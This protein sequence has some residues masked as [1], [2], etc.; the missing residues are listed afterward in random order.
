MADALKGAMA[1][2]ELK[3]GLKEGADV[4]KEGLSSV[5]GGLSEAKLG[6]TAKEALSSAA[7]GLAG[8]G[9]TVSQ[10]ISG[11][12]SAVKDAVRTGTPTEGGSSSPKKSFPTAQD[13][14][15]QPSM[16]SIVA[17]RVDGDIEDPAYI[18]RCETPRGEVWPILRRFST[19]E[20]LREDLLKDENPALKSLDFPAS[21][22]F[23]GTFG[24]KLFEGSG[25]ERGQD[26]ATPAVR[27]RKQQLESW[28]NEVSELCPAE[29]LLLAFFIDDNSVTTAEALK[30]G[31]KV[32]SS[33]P[34]RAAT[35]ESSPEAP[36]SAEEQARKQRQNR[37]AL[38]ALD[39]QPVRIKLT[40]ARPPVAHREG[41]GGAQDTEKTRQRRKEDE[42]A[43]LA[44]MR[45]DEPGSEASPR[46]AAEPASAAEPEPDSEPEPE[47]APTSRW[48]SLGGA[49]GALTSFK[50]E[51]QQE[52]EAVADTV[53][54][55][56]STVGDSVTEG[57]SAIRQEVEDASAAV[58][59]EIGPG[60]KAYLIQCRCAEDDV[61]PTR[62][63]SPCW[64]VRRSLH[65]V[66]EL[67]N[68]LL[69]DGSP[70]VRT[71]PFPT[72]IQDEVT[73]SR[74]RP[75][76]VDDD[77]E[78]SRQRL[79]AIEVWLNEVLEACV[80]DEALSAFLGREARVIDYTALSELPLRADLPEEEGQEAEPERERSALQQDSF[81]SGVVARGTRLCA[82][83]WV[84]IEG[85]GQ[86]IRCE[87][88][89]VCAEDA[90]GAQPFQLPCGAH[91]PLS[92]FGGA[93]TVF[94]SADGIPEGG[95]DDDDES[96]Y[97]YETETDSE[98]EVAEVEEE[99]GAEEEG[100]L[101]MEA[102]AA[103]EEAA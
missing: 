40:M 83:Q 60:W 44:A 19:F 2:K 45:E 84:A 35:E 43:A 72:K 82:V 53:T 65:D 101:T 90:D 64:H 39:A 62:R 63:A 26:V 46:P 88:G 91:N 75:S 59:A 77:I 99:V 49:F 76:W 29:P 81:S 14:E 7:G 66:V 16:I 36:P 57:I 47:P 41:G 73:M 6:D 3:D 28:I 87:G 50:D 74:L 68:L 31:I 55:K 30:I 70:A 56:L 33:A 1:A 97:S 51:I 69:K 103:A 71:I 11:G 22:L 96:D 5:T 79:Q 18:L 42:I 34:H 54:A 21:K 12:L 27:Q 17:T 58:R 89:W 86:W 8:V 92:L 94:V 25:K 10:G 52:L 98:E 100:E 4:L 13:L 102:K 32:S 20:K 80:G 93:G 23:F 37:R 78:D 24:Q 38:D 85:A 67:R 61:T 9:D 95:G 48:G 15:A